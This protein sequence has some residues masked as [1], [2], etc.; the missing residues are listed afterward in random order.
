MSDPDTPRSWWQTLPAVI[1]G[2]TALL[3]ALAGL[4]VA[5]KQTGWFEARKEIAVTTA[6]SAA[7][8]ANPPATATPRTP[9]PGPTEQAGAAPAAAPGAPRALRLP[10]MREYTLGPA[11]A[12]VTYT[13]LGA[14]LAP[15]NAE[16]DALTIRVRMIN[17]GRYD[18]NFWSRS[19]RLVMD[20]VPRAPDNVLDEVVAAESAKDGEV[21]FALPRGAAGVRLVMSLGDESTEVPLD[22]APAR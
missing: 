5:V 13:L 21:V 11:G 7:P 10:A 3:T 16:T 15:R 9:R 12:N 4:V 2:L 20:G 14:T 8:A 6:R 1:A 19:F 22:T 17:H 18:A